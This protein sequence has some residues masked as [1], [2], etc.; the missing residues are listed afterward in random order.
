MK[1]TIAATFIG[2]VMAFAGCEP[3]VYP[4]LTPPAAPQGIATRT[5]DGLV[6]LFWLKNTETDVA[7]YRVYASSSLNGTYEFIG[8]A[9]TPYFLDDGVT[10]GRTYFYAIA[11]YD[12]AGNES[13]LSKEIAYDTPR[14]EGLD[15]MM[16]NYRLWPN[17]GGYDFSTYSV[18][19]YD[20]QYTDVFFE[21]YNGAY[22]LNVW[23]DGEIQDMGYTGSLLDIGEAPVAGY[24]PTKDVQVIPGHT[25]VIWTWDNHFAKL[26]VT[27]LSSTKVIFDWAYQL[28]AGNTRLKS[29]AARGTL[30]MGSGARGR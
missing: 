9:R 24:S 29:P 12:N 16:Q 28:Q 20:D 13:E 5:G 21:Y 23:Q 15:V 25:Y 2:L 8:K 3:V 10:N 7:G 4:D 27:Q 26:R 22:Y 11:A 14:P 18:G 19:P 30:T 17:V 1:A 6:E